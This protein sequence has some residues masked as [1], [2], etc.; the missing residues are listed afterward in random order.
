M[1]DL[2]ESGKYASRAQVLR[3][4]EALQGWREARMDAFDASIQRGL[5]EIKAGGG[6]PAEEAFERLFQK[7]PYLR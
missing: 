2:I 6:V 4:S 5:A 1:L 7:Y 3:E